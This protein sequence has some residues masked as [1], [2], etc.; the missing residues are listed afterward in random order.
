MRAHTPRY[1]LC[2]GKRLPLDKRTLVMGILNTAPDSFSDGGLFF[3][4]EAAVEHALKMTAEGAD[5]IDIGGESTRPG[6]EPVGSSEELRRTIPV[7]AALRAASD[8]FVS[9][10]TTKATVAKEA[11]SSGADIINDV[12][13]FTAEPEIA[14]VAAESGAGV[15]LMHMQGTPRTMQINPSYHDVVADVRAHLCERMDAAVRAGID[16]ASIVVD[17]GIGFGKTVEHNLELLRRLPD[18]SAVAPLLVG[19]SRKHFIGQLLGRGDPVDRLAGSLAAAAFSV[20]R[21]ACILR[22]HD[23]IET[24]DVCRLVDRFCKGGLRCNGLNV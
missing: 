24:C 3:S 17:P 20:M 16:R 6:A 19:A 2:C 15:V 8:V 4:T 11:L 22:V 21:G 9:I 13:A 18:L 12:S 1:W 10:D 7:I 5:I 23:V 14:A